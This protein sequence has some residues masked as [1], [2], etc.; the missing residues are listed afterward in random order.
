MRPSNDV[1]Q[2]EV[3]PEI[4]TKVAEIPAEELSDKLQPK[5]T[6][7]SLD[8]AEALVRKAVSEGFIA[9]YNEIDAVVNAVA[10]KA[11]KKKQ[12]M[13][14]KAAA[15]AAELEAKRASQEADFDD[16]FSNPVSESF[17]NEAPEEEGK[18]KKR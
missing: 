7:G 18:G 2:A 5:V 14:A 12:K 15:E 4:K 8:M 10:E 6:K 1:V 3:W 11:E 9:A 16:A 13:E 17:E